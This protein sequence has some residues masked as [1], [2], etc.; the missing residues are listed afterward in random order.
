MG[1]PGQT[2]NLW[3]YST[4]LY[5]SVLMDSTFLSITV[6]LAYDPCDSGFCVKEPCGVFIFDW[7][8]YEWVRLHSKNKC[9]WLLLNL[10]GNNNKL[11]NGWAT[12]FP[13]WSPAKGKNCYK[14][15]WTT[16]PCIRSNIFYKT[17][18]LCGCDVVL[19]QSLNDWHVYEYR[20]G[21]CK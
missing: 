1:K 3:K 5:N 13:A 11:H 8:L 14:G 18:A 17:K 4:A 20:D 2:N 21:E 15:W 19:K 9:T 6:A 10:I 12:E 7:A 16:C